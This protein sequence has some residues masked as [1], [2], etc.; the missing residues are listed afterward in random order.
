MKNETYEEYLKEKAKSFEE[1]CVFCGECCGSKDDP[2]SKLLKNP[3]GNF[4]CEDYENRLGPQ[5]TISGKGFTC[6]S[7][8][9]HIANKTT[10][11]NCA[12]NR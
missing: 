12:Y 7:I 11:I 4:F 5:K 6:V 2:C 1:K 10:R 3:N 9:E 8:R